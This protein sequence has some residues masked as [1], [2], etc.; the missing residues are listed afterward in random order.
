MNRSVD[1]RSD[2][3][4]LGVV[5]YQMVTGS[6]PFTASDPMEWVHRHIARKPVPPSE[7]LAQT[8]APV[9]RIITTLL[10]KTAEERFFA[11]QFLHALDD[12]GLLVRSRAALTKKSGPRLTRLDIHDV[13]EEVMALTRGSLRFRHEPAAKFAERSS[14]QHDGAGSIGLDQGSIPAES[15]IGLIARRAMKGDGVAPGI[16]ITAGGPPAMF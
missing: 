7:R 11:I 3:Y 2:L 13:I 6:L 4:A 9:S 14:G 12:E 10:A 16:A 5:L 1:S 8:P 15:A